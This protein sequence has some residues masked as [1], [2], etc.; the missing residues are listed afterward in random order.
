LIDGYL[1]RDTI[2][3]L[4]ADAGVGKSF[5]AIDWMFHVATGRDWHGHEVKKPEPVLYIIGEDEA[6][7]G[8]RTRAWQEQYG[9]LEGTARKNV[10]LSPAPVNLANAKEVAELIEIVLDINPALVIVDTLARGTVGV[11]GNSDKDIGIVVE[12]LEQVRQACR[13]CV[14]VLHHTGHLNKGRGRGSSALPGALNTDLHLQGE[15]RNLKLNVTKQKN[16]QPA[17]TL[18]LELVRVTLDATGTTSCVIVPTGTEVAQAVD[19]P[20]GWFTARH[21][22]A[23]DALISI[24]N[25][26]EEVPT[27]RWHDASEEL[28]GPKKSQFYAIIKDLKANGLVGTRQAGRTTLN[29]VIATAPIPKLVLGGVS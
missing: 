2:A 6:G 9:T 26:G 23:L 22:Q 15:G 24:A 19:E 17:E 12:H 20:T 28:G 18:K 10:T 11:D 4:Y 27:T 1:V 16:D 21:S 5:L 3:E 8:L 13:A 7:F 29:T 25:E 14:L